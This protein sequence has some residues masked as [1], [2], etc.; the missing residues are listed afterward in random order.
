[1]NR[2][3]YYCTVKLDTMVQFKEIT[4]NLFVG[5]SAENSKHISG[6]SQN[7][8]YQFA[9]FR[10]SVFNIVLYTGIGGY[11][12]VKESDI[13]DNTYYPYFNETKC[14]VEAVKNNDVE[15]FKENVSI[16][17][18]V[19]NNDIF[20]KSDSEITAYGGFHFVFNNQIYKIY[21]SLLT[22]SEVELPKDEF[23]NIHSVSNA[24]KVEN[25]SKKY[26]SPVEETK[27]RKLIENDDK[28][29]AIKVHEPENSIEGILKKLDEDYL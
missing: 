19:I 5:K 13:V 8:L 12:P 2:K 11:Y 4:G 9:V 29:G 27:V 25:I 22:Y 10:S 26:V 6:E 18:A 24:V 17:Y 23:L 21:D 15:L 7:Y 20:I 3:F 14:T 28:N 1:M 16:E